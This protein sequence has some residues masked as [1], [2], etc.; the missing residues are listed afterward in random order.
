MKGSQLAIEFSGVSCKATREVNPILV[1]LANEGRVRCNVGPTVPVM[2][3][4]S[5]MIAM[6]PK[7]GEVGAAVKY[8]RGLASG[9]ALHALVKLNHPGTIANDV[10]EEFEVKHADHSPSRTGLLHAI[11]IAKGLH[12]IARFGRPLGEQIVEP[13][14]LKVGQL[15]ATP[16]YTG[17]G[18]SVKMVKISENWGPGPWPRE[19]EK[20]RHGGPAKRKSKS[21][22]CS[23]DLILSQTAS[24]AM[25]W[26]SRSTLTMSQSVNWMPTARR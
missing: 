14:L 21:S 11:A 8:L 20:V 7:S 17:L 10:E 3:I 1:L 13:T 26:S 25:S 6:S 19:A 23:L 9:G 5:T 16:R 4:H 2:L 24:S 18:I 15:E 22:L 12:D